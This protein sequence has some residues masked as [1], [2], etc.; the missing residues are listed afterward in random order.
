MSSLLKTITIIESITALLE[1]WRDMQEHAP[2]MCA[3]PVYSRDNNG[4]SVTRR[5]EGARD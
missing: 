4:F 3:K 1:G 2:Q 5:G